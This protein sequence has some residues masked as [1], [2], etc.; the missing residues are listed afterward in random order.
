M[1][2][3]EFNE[4]LTILREVAHLYRKGDRAA[5][6]SCSPCMHVDGGERKSHSCIQAP[7][8]AVVNDVERRLRQ[9]VKVEE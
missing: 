6:R 5:A 2:L 7:A 3:S 8:C 4:I 1:R 9:I